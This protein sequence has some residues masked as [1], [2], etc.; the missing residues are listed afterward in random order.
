MLSP[1]EQLGPPNERKEAYWDEYYSSSAEVAR[2]VPSQFA[3][4]VAGELEETH[5]V[6]EFGCGKGRDSLFLSS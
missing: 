2:S 4:F 3:T 1:N 6:V 5:R